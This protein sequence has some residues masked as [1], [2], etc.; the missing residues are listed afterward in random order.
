[1]QTGISGSVTIG[2]GVVMGGRV[3]VADHVEIGDGAMFG[4][5]SGVSKSLEGGKV[6]LD[7]PA[8]DISEA[9]RRL[10]VYSRLPEIARRL[11]SVERKLEENET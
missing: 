7:A 11:A 5:M 8:V 3:G 9:R 10:A 6:Y 2:R 4:A 1:S